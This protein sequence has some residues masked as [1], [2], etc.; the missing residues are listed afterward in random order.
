M[1]DLINNYKLIKPFQNEN[2]G[3]SRWTMAMKRGTIYFLK[4]FMDPIYPDE[5]SL[6]ET[7][8]KTRIRE[9][10]DFEA[11]KCKL[12]KAI[13]KVSDGNLIRITEFFRGDSHYYLTTEWVDHSNMSF[14]EIAGMDMREKLFLCRT[15]AH[16]LDALHSINI[17]HSDI[18]ETNVL[19]HKSKGGRLV[20]KIID[21]DSGFFEDCPPDNEDDLGGD[22]VYLS[23][24]ACLYLCGENV[25]LTCKMDVFAMGLLFYQYMTGNLPNFDRKKYSYAYEAVLD[26]VVLKADSENIPLPVREIIENMLLKDAEK[27]ISAKE[28]YFLMTDYYDSLF[29]SKKKLMD[30]N[31][32]WSKYYRGSDRLKMSKEFFKTE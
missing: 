1:A 32:N 6:E 22:Q 5:N 12:Y 19:V 26:D 21:Y 23:P 7:L 31:S 29:P 28:V 18:K 3:F 17:V 25:R 8:R 30:E 14:T 16:S 24:E 27:R 20:A 15:A 9:C 4:E 13:N 10:E 2:A 11:K